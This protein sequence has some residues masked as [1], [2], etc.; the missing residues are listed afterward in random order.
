ML[1]WCGRYIFLLI[2]LM[3]LGSCVND[4]E[5]VKALTKKYDVS[6]DVGEQVRIV[7]SDSGNVKLI[8]EAKT[9]E[10]FNDYS[11]P[12]DIFPNGIIITF[13]DQTKQPNSWLK[14]DYAVRKYKEKKMT[15]KGNVVFYNKQNDK[16]QSAE[17]IWDEQN[18]KIYTE[19]FIKVSRPAVGDT[20]YG[21]GFETDQNFNRIEIKHKVKG[22]IK[23]NEFLV[24]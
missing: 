18:K 24:E 3:F 9:L 2:L 22:K 13:L 1:Q 14:A 4:L 17:L 19:K 12:K 10:K 6:K 7:Y 15:V 11:D 23:A 20:I 21:V 5:E 8:I 16:L